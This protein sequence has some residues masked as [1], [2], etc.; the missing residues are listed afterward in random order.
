L[1]TIWS[2][3][4]KRENGKKCTTTHKEKIMTNGVVLI[5]LNDKGIEDVTSYSEEE[6]DK[7]PIMTNMDI[8]KFKDTH[9]MYCI[10]PYSSIDI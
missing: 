7:M 8:Q 3:C 6:E 10:Y 2:S 5:V 9:T 1:Q 4:L